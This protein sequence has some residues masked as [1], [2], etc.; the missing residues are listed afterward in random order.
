MQG[1]EILGSE[2]V[3]IF[4]RFGLTNPLWEVNPTTIIH[5][6]IAMGILLGII[7]FARLAVTS[8]NDGVAR[9]LVLSFVRFFKDLITQSLE[10]FNYTHFCMVTTLFTF[11]L[12]CNS[13]SI[14]PGLEEPT[15]DLNTTLAMGLLSF[16]YTQI[17]S[18]YTNG[19][20]AYIKEYFAP[21]FIMFPLNVVGQIASIVSISFRLFGNIFGGSTIAQLYTN[22]LLSG[23]IY[24]EVFGILTGANFLVIGF[25]GLFEG[26]IQAFVFAM[27]SLT[28]LSIA[29]TPK[30]T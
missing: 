23:S 22:G 21:F 17:Y 18:I 2:S 9:F 16:F 3:N 4:L 27:L 7:I 19:I 11:I 25:F 30:T 5:T 14:I 13:I 15:R 1:P 26:F 6:W 20:V 24:G 10:Q 12:L 8:K 29:V 28:Y